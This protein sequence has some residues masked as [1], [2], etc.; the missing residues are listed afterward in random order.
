[1]TRFEEENGVVG[2]ANQQVG[3]ASARAGVWEWVLL[4]G[5][6]VVPWQKMRF[7]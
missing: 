2:A 7:C 4:F 1:M 6:E 5:Q 3:T